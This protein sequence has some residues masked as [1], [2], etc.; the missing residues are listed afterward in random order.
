[1]PFVCGVVVPRS[2]VVGILCLL[3]GVVR[4]PKQQSAIRLSARYVEMP[5]SETK[6]VH[7][8]WSPANVAG[9]GAVMKAV[10]WQI[11]SSIHAGESTIVVEPLQHP[12]CCKFLAKGA[13]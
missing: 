5:H 3:R 1:M 7:G 12:T 2:A 13:E 10:V 6:V 4:N 8:V 9:R 11:I